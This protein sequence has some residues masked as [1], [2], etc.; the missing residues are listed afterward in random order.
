MDARCSLEWYLEPAEMQPFSAQPAPGGA[1]GTR[2]RIPHPSH[3]PDPQIGFV[4]PRPR[5]GPI[6][7]NSFSTQ[8]L[9][10]VSLG[11]KLALFGAPVPSSTS[12][13]GPATR[14][15]LPV[16]VGQIGFVCT[17]GPIGI[18]DS[19]AG[20]WL[21]LSVRELA[22]FARLSP[23]GWH[24]QGRGLGDGLSCPSAAHWVCL[25]NPSHRQRRQPC[26]PLA[27][28]VRGRIGFVLGGRLRVQFIIT[29]FPHRTCSSHRSGAIGFVWRGWLRRRQRFRPCQPAPFL[30]GAGQIGF[31]WRT[32]PRRV[33]SSRPP[34]LAM[35]FPARLWQIGFV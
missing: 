2:R 19:L 32:C 11:G 6:R 26:E 33:A 22:L 12:P 14:G 7:H 25:Y 34:D 4:F 10:F 27:F 24:R 31:V 8:C 18:A 35:V 21:L 20:H 23:A 30:V 5:A 13:C 15:P 16:G 28:A 29:L 3:R 9:P 1:A 17:T